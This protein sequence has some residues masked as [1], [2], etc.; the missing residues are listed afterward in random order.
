MSIASKLKKLGI[1][2]VNQID[3]QTVCNIAHLV[4]D[5][6]IQ[7]FPFLEDEYN[8]ILAKLLNCNMYSATINS[9]L[10]RVNYIHQNQ[11][12]YYDKSVDLNKISEQIV[13]E[14]V[15]YLQDFR[16][17]KGKTYKI[18]LCN[19]TDFKLIGIGLNESVVQY[20]SARVNKNEVSCVQEEDVKVKTISSCTEPWLTNLAEQLVFL[21]G[22][23]QIV[24]EAVCGGNVFSDLMLNTFEQYN[25]KIISNFDLILDVSNKLSIETNNE[26]RICLKSE[27]VNEYIQNERLIYKTYFEKIC[28]RINSIEEVEVYSKK[29]KEYAEIYGK[30]ADV[31]IGEEN[32]FETEANRITEMLDKC[33]FKINKENSK[34]M[35]VIIKT[36]KLSNLL[37]KI[38]SYFVAN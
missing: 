22:E 24:K 20:I 26:R 18:G 35:L 10:S 36:E 5:N 25:K 6:L 9:N 34:N 31:T 27:L 21:F 15:H 16:N 8:N 2:D 11:S 28:Q 12:I 30:E 33:L 14:C 29:L 3:K 13:H 19:V 32:Y 23:E 37:K 1:Q 17:R 7:T 38:K 4:A